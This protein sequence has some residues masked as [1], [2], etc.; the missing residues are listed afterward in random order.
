[1]T[2]PDQATSQPAAA[3]ASASAPAAAAAS[4][5]ASAGAA[6]AGAASSAT[7]APANA[8]VPPSYADPARIP[9]GELAERCGVVIVECTPERITATMP[10]AGNRQPFGLLHGGASA[11]LAETV[12]SVHATMLAGPGRVAV[13]VVLNFTHHLS[14]TEG[15]V[16]AVCTPLLAGRCISTFHIAIGDGAGRKVCTARLTCMT[17]SAQRPPAS[18]SAPSGDTTR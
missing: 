3:A 15:T 4:A 13:G 11:M 7:A 16:T 9:I 17:R 12:G 1:M 5:S 6:P 8:A 18:V 10:V 14:A 2:Q